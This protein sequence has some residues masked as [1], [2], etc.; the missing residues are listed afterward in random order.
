MCKICD[1]I[2]IK[3]INSGT[4]IAKIRTKKARPTNVQ[5]NFG[6]NVVEIDRSVAKEKL[7]ER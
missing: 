1:K 4:S 3:F 7:L 5:F 2:G 6:N